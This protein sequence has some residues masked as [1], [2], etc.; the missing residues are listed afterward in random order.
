MRYAE[1]KTVTKHCMI[2]ENGRFIISNK[3]LSQE[4][5]QTLQ[6]EALA[7]VSWEGERTI[8]LDVTDRCNLDCVHCSRGARRP[9]E[10]SQEL[11]LPEITR[12][13]GQLRG[14]KV[15]S[16]MGGEPF[17]RPDILHL[18]GRFAE[19]EPEIDIVTNLTHLEDSHIA[20]LAAPNLSLVVSLDGVCASTHDAIRGP[21]SFADTRQNLF[22]LAAAGLCAKVTLSMS[23]MLSNRR[24]VS[25]MLQFGAELG[26]SSFHFP[27]LKCE[28][29][30]KKNWKRIALSVDDEVDLME[31]L[32][33]AMTTSKVRISGSTYNL[34]RPLL[35]GQMRDGCPSCGKNVAI[36]AYANV[37]P[38]GGFMSERYALGNLRDHDM[39]LDRLLTDNPIL[40]E[41]RMTIRQRSQ[42]IK[43]QSDC[44][45]RFLCA[46]GCPACADLNSGSLMGCDSHC[47]VYRRFFESCVLEG[48]DE[49]TR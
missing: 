33:R 47:S 36:D 23:V 29:N 44:S 15:I 41:F 31:T 6:P 26:I 27:R 38:C 45:W 30:A 25:K 22:R 16:V 11:T 18:L 2:F 19:S 49:E 5:L 8:S 43:T 34:M 20:V 12:L 7:P 28:G 37:Y 24:E 35:A 17:L 1:I 40:K 14:T 48:P 9:T 21:G 10:I 3:T 13:I 39:S 4:Y 32:Y 46:G 42:A